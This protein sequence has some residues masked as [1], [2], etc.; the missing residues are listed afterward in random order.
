MSRI[1]RRRFLAI[2][3]GAALAGGAANR[4][5]AASIPPCG[6][7]I[8]AD[9]P[10]PPQVPLGKTG[11]TLSRIGQGTGMNG[12]GR[13]TNHTRMGIDRFRTLI[14]NSWERGVTFFD[15]ADMYGTHMYFREALRTDR[16]IPREKLT[17]LTKLWWRS[18]GNPRETPPEYQKKSTRTALERFRHELITDYIDIV[19]LH[20]LDSATWD[21]ELAAYMDVL[22]EAKQKKQVRAVGVSCHTL[23]ALKK[24]VDVPW[25]D[26]VLARINPDGVAMDGKTDVVV[27]VLRAIKEKGKAIIGMKIYGQGDL[28]GKTDECMKF[29]QGLGLLDAMT[30]GAEKPEEMDESLRLL[31]KYPA[32]QTA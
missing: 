30:L 29:A 23:E 1:G 17:L 22:S 7:P 32:A 13:Q 27:P 11:V 8:S 5:H 2:A 28:R 4:I 3:G 14:R 20:C 31:A 26:V 24:I 16:S 12:G 9:V 21:Q 15:M 10:P 6:T 18:D 19:L 25:V